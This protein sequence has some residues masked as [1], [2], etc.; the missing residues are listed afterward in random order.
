MHSSNY[1]VVIVGAGAAGLTAAIGL[2]K[3]G[4]AVAVVEAAAFPGAENWSGCV[5]FAENLAH[6]D[7]L[8]PE[9]VEEL[10]WERR[11]VE[12]GFFTT[13]GHSILGMTYRDPPAFK[14]CYTVLRPIYDHHLGQIAM[15]HGVALLTETT[16]ESLIRD[17]GRIVGVCTQRGPL[18]G[19]LVFLAEGDA[20]HLVT[21]EGY[22]RNADHREA[23]KFLQGIKQVIDLPP[24]AVEEVFGLGSDEGAAYEMLLRNGTLRGR[25]VHLNMGGFIYTNRQSL[26]VGLVLPADNL[27]EHFDGDPNLL[28]EWFENLP[29]LQP[30]LERGRRGVFGAKI[31]RGGGVRDVPTLIDEGLAIGGAAS[32]IGVDFPYPNFTGPATAM[33]LLLVQA[34]RR[35]RGE[36][37]AFTREALRRHYLEPLRNTH[38]WKDVEF[39]RRWPG[40]VKR[41]HVFFDTNIDLTLGTAY[42]WTRP[43]RWF[44]T[45]WT[46]WLRFVGQVV[47][48]ATWQDMGQDLRHLSRAL[49]LREIAQ[50]PELG[51]FLLD[52]TVNAL[53]DIFGRPRADLPEAGTLRLHYR[54]AGNSEPSGLPP[55]PLRLWFS[56]FGPILA[57]AARS[58]YTNNTTPL[59][60]K[61]PGMVKLLLHQVNVLDVVAVGAIALATGISASLMKLSD[62]LRRRRRL[63]ST[64]L[65]S[66]Y[67]AY[68][69]D[70][71]R[72]TD[73]TTAVAPAAQNWEARLG[74]LPYQTV[75][76][77]HIHVLWPQNLADKNSV[78]TDGL[79][80]VCPA[81]VYETRVGASG[82]VQVIVN[83]ENCIKCETC[84]RTGNLVDWGR[85]G[86]HRLVYAVP[87]P[88]VTRLLDA[89]QAAGSARPML[90]RALNWWEPAVKC[91]V[92]HLQEDQASAVNVKDAAV[93]GA[94]RRLL[95]RLERKLAEYDEALAEEPRHV[96]Q[97]R[98]EYLEMLARY[99]QQLA[100]KIQELF[101][102]HVQNDELSVGLAR[103]YGEIGP[104]IAALVTKTQERAQRTWNQR[105]SWAAA[106]GRQLRWHHLAGL[107]RFLDVLDRTGNDADST[108]DS[109][110]PGLRSEDD[111]VAVAAKLAEWSARLDAV[112]PQG[113]W[114]D[115]EHHKPLSSE[116]DA[117]LRDLIAQVPAVDPQ[118][119]AGT[120]HPPLRKALLAELGRRDPSLAY[121]VACHLWARDL[122]GL[123]SGAAA[124]NQAVERMTRADEWACFVTL[125]A[126]LSAGAGWRGEA[127]FV[128]AQ[129]ARTLVL[130]FPNQ[131]AI[132]P[133]GTPGLWIEPLA[134]LGLRGAGMARVR[135]DGLASPDTHAT[136]DHDR[137]RR[138]WS[139]L[140]SADLTSIA[141]GMADQ[142][143]RRTRAHAG[144]RVQFPGLFHDEEARDSIGKF[145]AVKKMVAEMFARR[146]LIETLDH[147][148]APADFAAS[149]WE[150]A[151]LIKAL[152]AEA[153]GTAPGSLSYNAGQ[154]FGGTGYSEDDILAKYYRDA[155]AWRFLGVPNSD[156]Y[157]RH[158]Y[159]LLRNWRP[160]GQ[161]LAA[162]RDEVDLFD[163]VVQRKALLGELDEVRNARSRLRAAVSEWQTK[164]PALQEEPAAEESEDQRLLP[165]LPPGK[166]GIRQEG[167]DPVALAELSELLAR[168]NAHL[169]ASKALVLR[170]HAHLEEGRGAEVEIALTRVWLQFAAGGLE[171]FKGTVQRLIEP[172][173]RNDHRPLV[174]L[175]AGPPVTVYA[176]YLAAS[177]PY[178]SGDFLTTPVNLLQPRLVPDMI[179]SDPELARADRDIKNLLTG[180][181]GPLRDGGLIYERYIE[182]NHRP[183]EADLDFCRQHGFFRMTIPQELGGKGRRKID[184][185]LVTTNAQAMVDVGISLAIQANTSIGTTPVLLARDKDL[186]KAQKELN[187]FVAD[188]NV[189]SE[190]EKGLQELKRSLRYQDSKRLDKPIQSF[191]KRLDEAVFGRSAV[192]IAAY[193]FGKA[194]Q[195]ARCQATKPF[196]AAALDACLAEA[197]AAW[198][199]FCAGAVEMRNEIGCRRKACDQFLQWV[200]QGQISAFALT[201]PSAGSDTARVATR[202]KPRS[203]PVEV[204]PD[205]VM[206]FIPAGGNEPR[207]LLDANR[208]VFQGS[209]A[210]YRWSEGAEPAP[211]HFEEYDY[212]TDN[213]ARM[214]FYD[215]GARRVHFTDIAQL[216]ERNGRLWYDYWE[217]TGAKMWI[218]NG[219]MCGIMCLYAKTDESAGP[220]VTGFIADRHAEGLI[221]G[222]DEEKLGQCG[223]PTNELS[224]QAVRVPRENVIG[225]EGRGQVN[226]LDTLN[227]GRAGLATSAVAQ[228]ERL[229]ESS[230]AFARANYGEIPN[231]VQWRLQQMEVARFTSE[232]LAFEVIGRFE[233]PQTKSVRMESAISKMLCSEMLH[234]IIEWAEEIRGLTG[235]T[236]LHL[237]E[238]RKRDARVLN[239]YE[240]TNE[241]QRFSV[242]KDLA[243][244]IGPRWS[245]APPA[246]PAHLSREVLELEVL[247]GT[248]RQRLQ[249][250]L[251]MFGQALWQNPNLQANCFLLAEA[252]AWIKAA[253]STLARLAWLSRQE[254]GDDGAGQEFVVADVARRALAQCYQEVQHRLDRFEE[255]LT[256]LR[257]G[258][259]APEVRAAGLLFDRTTDPTPSRAPASQI[260][261]PLAILVVLD[262]LT[263]NVPH[264]QIGGGRLLEPYRT[265][266]DA[267]RAALETALHLKERAAARVTVQVVAVGPRGT[268]PILREALNLGV[269][270]VRLVVPEA[271]AVTPDSAASALAAVLGTDRAFD[272][273]LGATGDK[274]SADGLVARLTAEA[275]GIRHAGTGAHLAVQAADGNGSVLLATVDGKHERVRSLPAAVGIEAGQVLRRYT[276]AGYLAGLSKSVEMVRWPRNIAAR[277]EAFLEGAQMA[278]RPSGEESPQPLSPEQAAECVLDDMGLRG[279]A[280]AVEPFEGAIEDVQHPALLETNLS[281]AG[282]VVAVLAAEADGRLQAGAAGTVRAARTLAAG[283]GATAKVLLLLGPEEETQRRALGHLRQWFAGDTVLMVVSPAV[284]SPEVRTRL[285]AESWPE[286]AVTPRVVVGEPWTESAFAARACRP[287]RNDT[288]ALR[289]R[290]VDWE[291]SRLVL[292]TARS[293]NKL[294][295]RQTV[296]VKGNDP[297]WLSVTDEVESGGPTADGRGTFRVQRWSPRLERFFGQADMQLLLQELKQETGLV[298][299]ADAEFIV[300]VGFGVGNRDGYESV[301]EPLVK[302]LH[303]LGVR[304]LVVGG[305]RKVTEELHLLPPDRQIG[306]SGVSVNPRI[307]LAI[308]ISGAPQHLNYI[309]Q[310]ATILAF[311]RDPE[312]PIMTLNQ[313]QARPRVFPVVGHLFET[314]PALIAALQAERA[315]HAERTS[316]VALV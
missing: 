9:G 165:A 26:S 51:K 239:I 257:R 266:S 163:Q 59:A 263:A 117:V 95:T 162:V 139:I 164:G 303:D 191:Q 80:H 302:T 73:L 81:H 202:A 245:K 315:G 211:I 5:Y 89:V 122:A 99:A 11:L 221:V 194:W 279:S 35:I 161:R 310:R 52:G 8:G 286:L 204:E 188:T 27:T 116:A 103:A 29:A 55:K 143:C 300:D 207:Y 142:L 62:R 255:E 31:I 63:F 169:L 282:S 33:G 107:R 269:D 32:A 309:D 92:G 210:A 38:Y 19:D 244:E 24:G 134:T 264:P 23:P 85:D 70:A 179:Q 192:K 114:R 74:R 316:A 246:P 206:R 54:V 75:K 299:L 254:V 172:A 86:R 3:A 155:S 121:S 37:T 125:D 267:D 190:I 262:P 196:D 265:W 236:Q 251:A 40:Y 268:A 238:K 14:H 58:V 178:D 213:P 151:G 66:L 88:V 229:I 205:G 128:P 261:R 46:N 22:E 247:K 288:L 82:Q 83:F 138:V 227:V 248:M 105:Y 119:L 249:A 68:A 292:Q 220:G 167:T 17:G 314:V 106:D 312:A 240:G 154:V 91:L 293:G 183:D 96:D 148:L 147:T 171:D 130:L 45:K 313:R 208:L 21:R 224:L 13:D 219:R 77:S 67:R 296:D 56:R 110:R 274:G 6:P 87:S 101:R 223:S 10:A 129:N 57:A 60:A 160:D 180:Q 12:R 84:W 1:D 278:A 275:L 193:R 127:L 289:V 150:Q 284:A 271:E 252:A 25:N 140:S 159:D 157:R 145:G 149:T 50:R 209:T 185:Y 189:Q 198:Q 111:N 232:A 306:Q 48:P 241:V 212:E 283:L 30:W 215:H 181:F 182:R 76:A 228:M 100:E 93:F 273:I 20:S 225:L 53:R 118:D 173:G 112:F 176:D 216:R 298:R 108:S 199:H 242:L 61:L 217:L 280:A 174:E 146:Y 308:G 290:R 94:M 64:G 120:L 156:I 71:R 218:T 305:S 72:A 124:W 137:M 250:A 187:A 237:V 152:A 235:Q 4:F 166:N 36:R 44:I 226:A 253:D 186:P 132:V 144:S 97:G 230:R 49:R 126:V 136:V 7:I 133:S 234:T 203:V 260:T 69:E 258:Y 90:P 2:A 256:H 214:R 197:L 109:L 135:L 259:Y 39:L 170:T 28:I 276:V 177:C 123:S 41:T 295:V 47:K 141:F 43:N 15:R 113:A 222:K 291:D 294:A 231:W 272:L 98:A 307:L 287:G 311:N 78:V 200:A 102:D 304:N 195:R 65:S 18:Y 104:L 168:Q 301:I 297:C 233:H 175:T 285:L 16:A 201:E 270:R 281:S 115:L 131:L 153:L 42:V 243:A 158:G 277:A 34:A 184:Y 79:W